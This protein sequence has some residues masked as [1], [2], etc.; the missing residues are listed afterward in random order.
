MVRNIPQITRS[1]TSA[2]AYDTDVTV[3]EFFGSAVDL[4]TGGACRVDAKVNND[5]I[6]LRISIIFGTS[7]SIGTMPLTIKTSDLPVTIPDYGDNT[8]MPGNF[9]AL[10]KADNS[11]KMYAPTLNN[12]GGFGNCIIFFNESG[13]AFTDYLMGSS[14]SVPPVAGDKYQ[15]TIFIPKM[16]MGS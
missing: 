13:A 7:M 11:V 8:P 3:T 6:W 1:T 2:Y 9:G 14:S 4:G 12:I 16:T 10:A 5:F 15:G